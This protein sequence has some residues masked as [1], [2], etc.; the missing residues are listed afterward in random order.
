ML[1]WID[2][3]IVYFR[4]LAKKGFRPRWREHVYLAAGVALIQACKHGLSQHG[5]ADPAWGNHQY[6]MHSG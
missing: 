6:F 1:K 3:D 4:H 2:D 5:I